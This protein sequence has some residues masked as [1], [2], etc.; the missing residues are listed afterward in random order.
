MPLDDEIE[1]Y[2]KLVAEDVKA[3]RAS[4][5]ATRARDFMAEVPDAVLDVIDLVH[6]EAN[7]KKPNE[8]MIHACIFMFTVGLEGNRY[9]I[10]RGH[11]WATEIV[12]T[13]REVLLLLARDGVIPPYLLMLLLN[14]FIEAKLAPGDALTELLGDVALDGAEHRAAPT[15]SE[16]GELF[17]SIV[18]QSGGNEFEVYAA[19]AEISDALPPEFRM[20]ALH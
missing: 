14:G 13:V 19:L 1:T 3:G 7:R 16:I 6:K 8:A 2:A 11:E 20:A 17:K 12:D 10:E 4:A 18:E 9:Q 15:A 5:H